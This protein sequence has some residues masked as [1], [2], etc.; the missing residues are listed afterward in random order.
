[1]SQ[2]VALIIGGLALGSIYALIALGFVMVFKASGALNFAHVSLMLI[3]AYLVFQGTTSW[4][5]GYWGALAVSMVITGGGAAVI[6]LGIA[7]P[8]VGRSILAV[9]IATIGADIMMRSAVSAYR[10]WGLETAEV[11]SPW[12]NETVEILGSSVFTSQLWLI[13]FGIVIVGTL[14]V[15][16][17]RFRWGLLFRAIAEDEEAAA[18]N[19]VKVRKVLIVAWILSGVLAAI[20]GSFVGTFPRL[21]QPS[22]AE[23]ALRSLPAVVIGGMDSVPG[24]V[25]GGVAV[26]LVEIYTARYAP[27]AL[28]TNFHLLTPYLLMMAVLLVR[29]RGLFAPPEVRR[30]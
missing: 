19:G 21:L 23:F 29:G 28:G 2:Q 4:G 5:L 6:F 26:G 17:Q 30:V 7:N 15:G 16:F 25:I 22:S 11:G 1:M 12:G 18:A 9:S 24:A 13:G 27:Q 10:P 20:A 8:L 3:G 14:V